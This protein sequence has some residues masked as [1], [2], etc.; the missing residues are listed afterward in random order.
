MRTAAMASWVVAAAVT[1]AGCGRSD[2][3]A[4]PPRET[5]A[6]TPAAETAAPPDLTEAMARSEPAGSYSFE[7]Y[8]YVCNGLE[9]VVRPGKEELTLILPDRTVTL[10][11]VVAASGARYEDGSTGFWGK[12]INTAL[13]TLDDEDISCM[14][15]RRETPW[16]DARARGALFRAVGQEPGWQLEIHPDRLVMVYQFGE[17]RAATPNPGALTDPGAEGVRRWDATTEAHVLSITV[18]DQECADT[19]SGELFPASV[20]VVLDGTEFVGCG[21]NLE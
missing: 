3:P 12:G 2:P 1:L 5:A 18:H 21:R 14:L 13:L 20:R 19:M 4:P 7:A 9:I 11:Q 15:D 8:A 17:R 6:A 16:A 10:P